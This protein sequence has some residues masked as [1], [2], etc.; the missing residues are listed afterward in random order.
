MGFCLTA[1]KTIKTSFKTILKLILERSFAHSGITYYILIDFTN[2]LP[3]F[4]HTNELVEN[5][6]RLEAEVDEN[7]HTIN[8]QRGEEWDE[9]WKNMKTNYQVFGYFC[10]TQ[11][12]LKTPVGQS[13]G[14]Y[15]WETE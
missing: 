2:Q 5:V 9:I 3:H 13:A 6:I 11:V 14:Q 15:P 8:N 10:S 1:F 12:I 4:V 7:A